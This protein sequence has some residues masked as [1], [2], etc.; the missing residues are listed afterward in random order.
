MQDIPPA[1]YI[2]DFDDDLFGG[3]DS[4]YSSYTYRIAG[5]RNMGRVL[6]LSR[7]MHYD[8]NAI[9]RVD[10]HLVNWKLHL[11]ESK[12]KFIS[13]DGQLD[14]MIFQAHMITAA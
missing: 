2:Q 14:E 8:E 1:N 10:A 11:P 5:I 4:P 12:K 3:G 9:S 13:G 6:S 7:I